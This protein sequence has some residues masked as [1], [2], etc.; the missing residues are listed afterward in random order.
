MLSYLAQYLLFKSY[1]VLLCLVLYLIFSCFVFI[2]GSFARHTVQTAA[3]LSCV[4]R[5]LPHC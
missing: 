2:L 5:L 1:V 4:I 3:C